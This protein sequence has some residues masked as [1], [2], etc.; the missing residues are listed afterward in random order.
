LM[1]LVFMADFAPSRAFDH[2]TLSLRLNSCITLF[3]RCCRKTFS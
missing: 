1:L 3:L 2:E